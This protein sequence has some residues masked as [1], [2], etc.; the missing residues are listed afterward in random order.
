MIVYRNAADTERQYPT[1]LADG[2]WSYTA[3]RRWSVGGWHEV[4]I[5][6]R[7]HSTEAEAI[8]WILRFIEFRDPEL[9]TALEVENPTD[10]WPEAEH[11]QAPEGSP[12]IEIGQVWYRGGRAAIVENY[13]PHHPYGVLSVLVRY[14]HPNPSRGSSM[15][16]KPSAN[17]YSE[18][19][20]RRFYRIE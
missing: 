13:T 20:F 1:Q 5:H 4:V 18:E 16:R 7:S 11:W 2:S 8:E 17:W 19:R 12:E 10:G 14:A 9:A 3:W 6:G 15:H